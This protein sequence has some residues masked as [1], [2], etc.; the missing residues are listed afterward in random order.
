MVAVLVIHLCV[1]APLD[2]SSDA[3]LSD[4]GFESGGKRNFLHITDKDGEQPQCASVSESN[5]RRFLEF[6]QKN[7]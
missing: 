7:R 2:H 6:S 1:Q 4:S 3:A 5:R